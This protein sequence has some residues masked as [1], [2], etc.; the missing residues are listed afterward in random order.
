MGIALQNHVSAQG[1]FPTGGV[2]P[3]PNIADFC[4]G[5]TNNPG[6]PNGANKQGLGWAYQILPFLEQNAI[7][8]IVSQAQLQSSVV[9]LYF[10]P[11]RRSPGKV[12][13]GP[14]GAVMTDYASAQPIT[15]RSPQIGPFLGQRADIT[16]THPFNG[17]ASYTAAIES[18]WSADN[19]WPDD[20]SVF[21]GVIVKTPWRIADCSPGANCAFAT[22]TMPGRGEVPKGAPFAVKPAEVS[23]GLS[24]TM[25][26]SEKLVR[27]DLYEGGT[28]RSDDRGWADGWDP[29]IVRFTGFAPIPDDNASICHHQ[30][31]QR[32]CTGQGDS[33]IFFFGSAHPNGINSVYA[34]A[35]CHTIS[36]NVDILV[37]NALGTRNGEETIDLNQ[38]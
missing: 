7:K 16:K 38:L 31:W 26:I 12:A 28:S 15:Y 14:L 3:N 24:N 6:I 10:C 34:D 22:A 20:Y 11:S 5:G 18:Y 21:D 13:G 33:D 23:D 27:T 8:G 2:K 19:G 29:D 25:V 37:F 9:P 35:S 30:D 32:F 1:V 4:S 17:G 36:Y